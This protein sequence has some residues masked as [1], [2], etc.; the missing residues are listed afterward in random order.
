MLNVFDANYNFINIIFLT[1]SKKDN[2]ILILISGD[3]P[4]RGKLRLVKKCGASS[5]RNISLKKNNMLI[6]YNV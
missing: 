6:M 3:V 4:F 1:T 2:R 5:S